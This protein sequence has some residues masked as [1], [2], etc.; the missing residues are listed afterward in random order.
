MKIDKTTLCDAKTDTG[1]GTAAKI[2]AHRF[3]V[4]VVV[5][6]GTTPAVDVDVIG[7]NDGGSNYAVI[8]TVSFT[9]NGV[10]NLQVDEIWEYVNVDIT[11]ISGGADVTAVVAR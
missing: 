5:A 9:D 4:Q 2:D 11:S 10:D 3:N 1:V 7:S 8:G 6:N